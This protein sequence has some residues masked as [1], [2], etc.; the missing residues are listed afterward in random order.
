MLGLS[1]WLLPKVGGVGNKSVKG[2][3]S[4]SPITKSF[5]TKMSTDAAKRNNELLQEQKSEGA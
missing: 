3:Q 2:W 4:E 5:L 1:T